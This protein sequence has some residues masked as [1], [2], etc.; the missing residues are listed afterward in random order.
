MLRPRRPFSVVFLVHSLV[1]LC[2]GS[3]KASCSH[4]PGTNDFPI[5]TELNY[6]YHPTRWRHIYLLPTM[7][8]WRGQPLWLVFLD[9]THVNVT[10][11]TAIFLLYTRSSGVLFFAV[12]A[13]SCSFTVKMLKRAI[14]QPR[15]TIGKKKTFGMPSTHSATITYFGTYIPLACYYLPIHQRLPSSILTRLIP[16]LIAVPWAIL[17]VMSRVWLGHHTWLQVIAGALYGLFWSGL[18]FGTWVSGVIADYKTI[19][20]FNARWAGF[21]L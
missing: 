2:P 8:T 4:V 1:L 19:G 21:E 9:T 7:R 15:P 14:R 10:A 13:L 18:W 16:P 20:P 12:G 5:H 11:F 17:V 3:I 6:F